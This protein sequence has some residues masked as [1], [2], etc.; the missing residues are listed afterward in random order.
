[1]TREAV[2]CAS[3]VE[4]RPRLEE[5]IGSGLLKGDTAPFLL[6]LH[7]AGPDF[8]ASGLGAAG[9]RAARAGDGF[10]PEGDA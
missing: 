6:S 2:S 10:V 4:V 7:D 5:D 8:G 3:R 9:R 1:M